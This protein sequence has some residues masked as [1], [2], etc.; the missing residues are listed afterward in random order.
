MKISFEDF[1]FLLHLGPLEKTFTIL[2]N[3][4]KLTLYI[5]KYYAIKTFICVFL[6]LFTLSFDVM[7]TSKCWVIK[8]FYDNYL[9]SN[10]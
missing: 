9:F 10:V 8:Y 5:V 6:S 3:S 7:G 2:E 4:W 1:K